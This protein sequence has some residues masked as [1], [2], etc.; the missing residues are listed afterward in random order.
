MTTNINSGAPA[1]AMDSCDRIRAR[2]ASL[3]VHLDQHPELA[4]T[5]SVHDVRSQLAIQIFP[6]SRGGDSHL[7]VLAEWQR[8]LGL[9]Q[10]V[11][12]TAVTNKGAVHLEMDGVLCDGSPIRLFVLPSEREITLLGDH[13]VVEEGAMFPA[14]LVQR[15]AATSVGGA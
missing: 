7:G 11:K 4:D 6:W 2:L 12:V 3:L 13:V 14:D 5:V 8:T 1:L 9:C 10:P 15:L